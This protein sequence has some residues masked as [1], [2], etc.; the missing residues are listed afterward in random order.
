MKKVL[1]VGRL[2]LAS[3]LLCL[4]ASSSRAQF[5]GYPSPQT[6]SST[7][8]SN[9]A[10]TGSNQTAVVQNLG[11]TVHSAYLISTTAGSGTMVI[12]GSNDGVNF[13]NISEVATIAGFIAGTP[14]SFVIGSGY[15]PVVRVVVNCPTTGSPTFTVQYSGTSVTAGPLYGAQALTQFDK[16][17]ADGLSVSSSFTQNSFQPP[18]GNSAGTLYFKYS[19]ANI[20]TG[21]T[22]AIQCNPG[23]AV[24]AA[25]GLISVLSQT[26]ANT[27]PLQVFAV[28]AQP[29]ATISV[30]YTSGGAGAATSFYCDYLFASPGQ[31]P[32][33][34]A[35][36]YSHITG[37]TATVVKG[38]PGFLHTLTVNLGA[39]TVVSIFDL[40]SAACTGTPATNQVANITLTATTLQTFI[41]DVTMLN[42]ICVKAS[43]TGEDLTVSYQ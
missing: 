19:G 7:P 21:S 6:V 36:S 41:Y 2:L 22:I 4:F 32:G 38:T 29:C 23:V 12:Q 30:T 14:N 1:R 15:Y 40:A 31:T 37:I 43:V 3:L 25:G 33:S 11:Q 27:A 34:P 8:F 20:P 10:C 28:A 42:G 35:N 5:S 24:P 13:Q 17:I 26:L 16:T 39:A 18:F 9:V